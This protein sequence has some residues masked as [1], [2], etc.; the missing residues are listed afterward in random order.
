MPP[1]VSVVGRSDAGKTTFLEKL[2]PELK[3]GYSSCRH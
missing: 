3:K 1:I 2:I